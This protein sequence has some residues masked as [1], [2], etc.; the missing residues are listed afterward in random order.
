M[1]L[2]QG[3][4]GVLESPALETPLVKYYT[5]MHRGWIALQIL[6]SGADRQAARGKFGEVLSDLRRMGLGI[7]RALA[8]A[9]EANLAVLEGSADAAAR[10]LEQGE[11][12]FRAAN[13]LCFAAC[14]RKRRGQVVGGPVGERVE[15]EADGQLRD[16]GVRDPDKWARAYFSPFA[17]NAE[18]LLTIDDA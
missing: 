5:S 14:A 4:R 10:L 16:F 3:R 11:Q 9:L 12:G 1:S 6:A 17:P 7:S 18:H 13:M 8:D 15:R 2:A